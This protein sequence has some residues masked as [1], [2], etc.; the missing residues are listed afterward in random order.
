M[1]TNAANGASTSIRDRVID[2]LMALADERDWDQIEIGDIAESAGIT[3]LE[4]RDLFPSKGAILGAFARRIDH[5]VLAAASDDLLGETDKDRIFDVLMRRFDA[6]S[7][8]KSALK[9]MAPAIARDPL[10]VAALNQVALNSM[11]FM[12]ASAGIDTEGPLGLLKLQGSVVMFAKLLDVWFHDEDPGLSRTMAA[13]DEE[14]KRG[15]MILN[16]LGDLGRMTAPLSN[17][18]HRA[19]EKGW[20]MASERH[21]APHGNPDIDPS[22]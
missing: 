4:L 2:A 22:I 10:S 18:L 7:P 1:M 5:T 14:L 13:M 11:R 20:Q 16:R 9:R 19:V 12:L 6:L 17:A 15:G 3:L 8:Y 21:K